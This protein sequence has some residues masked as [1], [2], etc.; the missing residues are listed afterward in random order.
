MLCLCFTVIVLI[1]ST[2]FY[3]FNETTYTEHGTVQL[4]DVQEKTSRPIQLSETWRFIPN[5]HIAP[6]AFNDEHATL[7]EMPHI[8]KDMEKGTYAIR[9]QVPHADAIYS[10]KFN[11]YADKLDI[12]VN[13]ERAEQV[14]MPRLTDAITFYAKE[15]EIDLVIHSTSTS[16]NLSVVETPMFGTLEQINII[17][18]RE[19]AFSISISTAFFIL[20]I[21]SLLLYF[22]RKQDMFFLNG[23]LCILLAGIATLLIGEK[24]ILD[25]FPFL[26]DAV[27]LKMK[28]FIVLVSAIPLITL[29]RSLNFFTITKRATYFFTAFIAIV[30]LISVF[31]PSSMYLRFEDYFFQYYYSF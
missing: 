17:K 19:G 12:W 5:L 7:I 25:I 29:L 14:N 13:N 20:G 18:K 24:V 30:I 27:R 31:F 11:T 22:S 6:E 23:G 15:K 3:K 4:V 10:F 2:Q 8:M 28:G 1:L 9:I 16:A 26:P 21:Y